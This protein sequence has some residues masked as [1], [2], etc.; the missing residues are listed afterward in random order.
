MHFVANQFQY[1]ISFQNDSNASFHE[2]YT[3][4][5]KNAQQMPYQDYQY[6]NLLY[7]EIHEEFNNDEFLE[8]GGRDGNGVQ[9]EGVDLRT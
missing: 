9:R 3:S 2:T 7:D 6:Q 4:H 1:Q 5:Q 8:H